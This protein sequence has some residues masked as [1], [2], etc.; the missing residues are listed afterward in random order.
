[1]LN[2]KRLR[3][4]TSIRFSEDTHRMLMELCAK[5][6]MNK[7]EVIVALIRQ[8]WTAQKRLRNVSP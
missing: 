4:A 5:L 2:P 3:A 6:N 8:E 1:M 7:R